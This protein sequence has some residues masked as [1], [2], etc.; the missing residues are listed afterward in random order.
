MDGY[1]IQAML[2]GDPHAEPVYKG[3]FAADTLP[4]RIEKYPAILVANTDCSHLPGTHWVAMAIDC[5]G[6]G[7]F[8]DSYGRSPTVPSH[9]Q[10]MQRNCTTW[11][12]SPARLQSIG[13]TVC[14]HYC[15]TFLLH[16]AHRFTLHNFLDFFTS[17][18]EKN[19]RTVVELMK[20]Y[21]RRGKKYCHDFPA[22]NQ[23]CC[24]LR[25]S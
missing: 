16:W 18:T 10:F 15:V 3:V 7:I 17:D 20:S 1:A 4:R 12:S 19:D 5:H 14:G 8:F 23:S 6:R 21:T 9:R 25:K 24:A 22:V 13:T 11:K 2:Q